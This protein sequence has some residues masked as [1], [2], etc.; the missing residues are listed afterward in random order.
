MFKKI[1]F[2]LLIFM[3]SF[4][5][6]GVKGDYKKIAYDFQF[7]D[8]NGNTL[9]LSKFKNNVIVV[10]NVASRCG[11]TKQ[12]EDMQKIW[13]M[14]KDKGVVILGVPSNDFNQELDTNEEIKKFCETNFGITFPITEK[15]IV[16]GDNAHP[17]FL[18]AKKNHGKSA[19]P[20]WNFHKIIIGRDG[21]VA[22][23]FSSIT[24]PSSKKFI[25]ALEKLI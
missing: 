16:K 9:K 22:E 12:Y 23:T 7:N 20:K 2:F 5:S 6:T 18:W 21:K 10:I 4:L 17:F 8:I 1:N 3:I 24:N 25:I 13:E 11:F 15:V 19:V 14:Y